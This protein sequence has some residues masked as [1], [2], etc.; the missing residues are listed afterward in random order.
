MSVLPAPVRAEVAR[1]PVTSRLLV[2]DC[3]YFPDAADHARARPDGSPGTIVILC[4]GG[5]GWCRLPTGSYEVRAGEALIV[6]GREPHAYGAQPGSPWTI[7]WAHVEGEDVADLV[8]ATG[9]T[10][11]RPVLRSV[12]A[13]RAAELVD[14]ALTAMEAPAG[15][16]VHVASGAVWHLLTR[17][18]ADASGSPSRA[19]PVE[20]AVAH[21]RRRLDAP[22][23]VAELAALV[24][25]SPSHLTA[26]F[27]RTT[28]CGPS[29]YHTRLRMGRARELLAGSDLPVAAVAAA[30][31]Y[32]DPFHF[33]RRFRAV[34]GEPPSS[35]RA[36]SRS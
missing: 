22:V 17:L 13:V 10:A 19:D 24:G 15:R 18:G 6:P 2:T 11:R 36:R 14:E 34:H 29:E 20:T 7:W 23:P 27:R 9:V 8:A 28:G 5:R 3:G 4:V 33:A 16:G 1:R 12:D 35:Y 21:L 25:L 32:P 30:V 31:G 26:L